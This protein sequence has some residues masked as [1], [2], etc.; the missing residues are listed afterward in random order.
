[1]R[2]VLKRT[3]QALLGMV[4]TGLAQLRKGKSGELL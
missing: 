4:W 2:V 1:V 3:S